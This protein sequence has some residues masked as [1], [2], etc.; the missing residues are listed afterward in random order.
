[1]LSVSS[2]ISSS[3]SAA[4]S[5]IG[6]N[7]DILIDIMYYLPVK[8]LCVFRTVS[9]QWLS[10]ISDPYFKRNYNL[11]SCL[12]SVP[13]LF[14][15]KILM[16]EAFVTESEFKT[17]VMMNET[18]RIKFEHSC[19]GLVLYEVYD[20]SN[21]HTTYVV[22]NPSM[23]HF[24]TLLSPPLRNARVPYILSVT[25][26]FDPAKSSY[27]EVVGVCNTDTSERMFHIEIYSSKTDSWRD[28]G[29][30]FPFSSPGRL[31]LSGV[32]WNGSMHWIDQWTA[33]L[34]YFDIDCELMN[35][36][37]MPTQP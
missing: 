36:I 28:A 18:S 14:M 20:G 6:N 15:K 31:E 26:A 23:K 4:A 2:N 29:D 25:I 13:A 9:K 10:L 30:P 21:Y 7:G 12:L 27:Y 24:K 32:Y 34:H 8:S 17:L 22:Y 11:R 5:I 19:N 33:T 35:T 1:M 16:D 3:A 37:A